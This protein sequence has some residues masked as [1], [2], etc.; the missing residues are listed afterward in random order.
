MDK[1]VW[2]F[3]AATHDEYVFKGNY[4]ITVMYV[5]MICDYYESVCFNDTLPIYYK[6]KFIVK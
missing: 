2:I 4:S 3:E 5:C 6:A 1:G